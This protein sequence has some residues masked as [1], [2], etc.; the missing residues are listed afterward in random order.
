[1]YPERLREAYIPC[2]I[3]QERYCAV[4]TLFLP[5]YSRVTL[6]FPVYSRVTLLAVLYRG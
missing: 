6:L 1:V 5:V 3:A 4:Y 2:C